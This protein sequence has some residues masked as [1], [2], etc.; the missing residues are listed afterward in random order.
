MDL[1]LTNITNCSSMH[2]I[3]TARI[4]LVRRNGML[5][6]ELETAAHIAKIMAQKNERRAV[7][8]DIQ[9]AIPDL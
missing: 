3:L 6:P 2:H 9:W 4:L 7:S 5:G 1:Q 8:A